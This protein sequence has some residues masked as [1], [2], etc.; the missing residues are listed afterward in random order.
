MIQLVPSNG[1]SIGSTSEVSKF[2]QVRRDLSLVLDKSVRYADVEKLAYTTAKGLMKEVNLFDV[3]E[4][5]EHLGEDKKSYAVS[6]LFESIDKM[7]DDKQIEQLFNKLI[8]T[9]EKKLGAIIRQ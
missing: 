5:K 6:F 4:S 9:Y 2:P 8:A 1:K 7:I 3:F